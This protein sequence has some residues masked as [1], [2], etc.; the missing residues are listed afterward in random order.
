[1]RSSAGPS[2]LRHRLR[3]LPHLLLKA[4]LHALRAVAA[5]A[6]PIR[7]SA[8]VAAPRVPIRSP[9]RA[10][11][12]WQTLG[13]A[14]GGAMTRSLARV[15]AV[16]VGKVAADHVRI[17]RSAFFRQGFGLVGHVGRVLAVVDPDFAVVARA[18][19][20]RLV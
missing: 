15:H 4:T 2:G 10:N 9:P 3:D 16:V 6:A 7:A 8:L 13:D 19:L 5:T 17:H 14:I 20:V 1:M 18:T 11:G 12:H